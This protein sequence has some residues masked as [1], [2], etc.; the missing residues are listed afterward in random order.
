MHR[1]IKPENIVIG[2][3]GVYKICDYDFIKIVE[4]SEIYQ[5]QT[6]AGSLLYQAPEVAKW[7]EYSLNADIF[8]TGMMI[9]KCLY[10]EIPWWNIKNPGERFSQM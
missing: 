3:N 9:Y 2:K 6:R 5:A 4:G 10:G 8:S 7:D 1:D